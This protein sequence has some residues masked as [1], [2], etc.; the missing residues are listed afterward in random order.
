LTEKFLEINAISRS[1][2]PIAK[3]KRAFTCFANKDRK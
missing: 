3:N 1:N 2:L